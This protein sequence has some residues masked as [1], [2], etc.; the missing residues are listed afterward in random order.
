MPGP[1]V[2]VVDTA[3]VPAEVVVD[4]TVEAVASMA[5]LAAASAEAWVV[6]S[7]AA[8]VAGDMDAV[9]ATGAVGA[10][11]MALAG[12]HGPIGP[13]RIM[14]ITEGG[15]IPTIRTIQ[16]IPTIPTTRPTRAIPMALTTVVFQAMGQFLTHPA[17]FQPDQTRQSIPKG[18]LHRNPILKRPLHR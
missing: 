14:A 8:T 3:E 16:T 13:E 12:G 9:M 11:D 6:D 7:E 10:V 1:N 5:V 18:M 4:S 15:D 2:V 17:P